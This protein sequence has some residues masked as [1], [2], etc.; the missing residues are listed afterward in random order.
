MQHWFADR[1]G[2]PAH[3][4]V[5]LA[6][7]FSNQCL[8]NTV[9]PLRAANTVLGRQAY[10]W[11]LVSPDGGPVIS[12]SG[13]RVMPEG[14]V[15][16]SGAGAALVAMPA[17]GYRALAT[18]MLGRALR[19]AAR[20]HDRLIGLDTGAWLFAAAGV[21]EGRAATIH[22]AERDAFAETFPS[23]EVRAARWVEDGPVITAGGAMAAFDLILH[24]LGAAH[25]SALALEVARNFLHGP[26]AAPRLPGDRADRALAAALS[27][28]EGAVQEPLP[29]PAIAKAAGLSQR[30]LEQRFRRAFGQGPDAIYRRMRLETARRLVREGAMPVAEVALR[31]GWQDASAFARAYRRAFGAAP[32]RDLV[33]EAPK[34]SAK[35]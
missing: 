31:C 30:A 7:G 22:D 28:M 20:R 32:T 4:T 33:K 2:A 29:V 16:R 1:P 35:N 11:A 18:P 5:L 8:A 21:L 12:S 25:G 26:A 10:S 14:A 27:A 6:H 19:A 3:V 9:E 34:R 17:F 24:L 13:L 23:V 15:S